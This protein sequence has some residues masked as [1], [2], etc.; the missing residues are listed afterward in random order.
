MSWLVAPRCTSPA[1]SPPTSA[2]S[3][4]TSGAAG[5]P[6]V[7]GLL[8]Q[9]VDVVTLGP[10]CGGDCL[11]VL[12]GDHAGRRLRARERCLDVEQRLQPGF[13]AHRRAGAPAGEDPVEEPH[14]PPASA[15]ASTRWA[16]AKALLAAGTPA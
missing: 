3:A 11:G 15:S 2:R 9:R 10:A 16:T 7:R 1:A 8:A 4:R 12:G 5:L 14:Q 13:V 6:D